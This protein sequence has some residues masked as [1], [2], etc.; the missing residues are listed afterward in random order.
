M[1]V[2][3][4]NNKQAW[5]T[6]TLNCQG[7]FLQSWEWGNFQESLGKKV[8]H[9]A[10]GER[11]QILLQAQIIKEDFLLGKSLVYLPFGPTW[12]KNLSTEKI[13]KALTCLWQKVGELAK[14]EQA[15]F[16]LA[17]PTQELPRV[18]EWKIE[19]PLKR[20]Q[21]QE[22]LILD[23]TQN[24][25][26]IF[27]H[28]NSITRYNI[29]LAQRKGVTAEAVELTLENIAIFYNLMSKTSQ[30]DNFTSYPKTYFE[31]LLG[32]CPLEVS[33]G[34]TPRGFNI[35]LF[36]AKYQGKVVATNIL[37]YFGDTATHLH[38]AS[39]HN[40][41]QV[42]APQFLQWH[43]IQDAQKAG[44]SKYD[45]WGISATKWPSLTEYKKGFSGQELAYPDGQNLVFQKN[46]YNLYK[47]TRKLLRK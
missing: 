27:S 35:K 23:L 13:A 29:R 17:E 20:I 4:N 19:K 11:E 6:F 25:E 26:D 1:E 15:I 9:L 3:Q 14:Q 5:N 43:Q 34:Q 36:F 16:C 37:V 47:L 21:P 45:F 24:A 32:V 44:F 18:G 8:W 2:N 41:R 39:D 46:W 33:R 42:K 30:R 12:L 22:T 7:S 40:F 31:K 28:F 38:G 10:I